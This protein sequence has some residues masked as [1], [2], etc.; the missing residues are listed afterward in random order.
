[1]SIS[2][3]MKEEEEHRLS[4]Y[5]LNRIVV[6]RVLTVMAAVSTLF[7][8][9]VAT[10]MTEGGGKNRDDN[11]PY[12]ITVVIA[13]QE[14]G[15][16]AAQITAMKRATNEKVWG[17]Y[18]VIKP[19]DTGSRSRWKMAFSNPVLEFTVKVSRNDSGTWISDIEMRSDGALVQHTTVEARALEQRAYIGEPIDIS[20]KDAD[21]RDVLFGLSQSPG[22]ELVIAPEV[23]G[24]VTINVEN[25]PWDQLLE[26]VVRD[27][28][29]SYKL[30]GARLEVY[31]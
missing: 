6:P 31:K 10:A 29:L 24:T 8:A 23:H 17:P 3:S 22:L 12:A 5:S 16:Y 9:T 18:L 1:M 27:N 14:A 19:P 30:E 21:V 13:P 20:L 11:Q 26:Q 4:D 7:A 28:G 2:P 25:M 15:Q